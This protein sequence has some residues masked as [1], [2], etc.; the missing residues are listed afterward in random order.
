MI[1][2]NQI[3]LTKDESEDKLKF[4]AASKLKIPVSDIKSL[5][6]VKKSIDARKKDSIFYTYSLDIAANN[7]DKILKKCKE[8]TRSNEVIYKVTSLNKE[9]GARPVIVGCGPAGL[10]CAYVLALSGFK[11]IVLERGGSVDERAKKVDAFWETGK[12]D[13]ET[14]VQFGEGGAGTFSDGK[15]N[16]MVKDTF[17]RIHFVLE[18]FASF[19]AD[20][21][22]VYLNKPHIGTDVLRSVIKNMR[23]K[24]IE[25]GG[26]FHFNTK[27]TELLYSNGQ[28][29]G[30]KCEDGSVYKTDNVVL[31]IGHSA[32]DTFLMLSDFLKMEPKAFAMGVRCEHLQDTIGKSQYG[33]DYKSYPPADYKLTY[34]TEKGRSVYS[35]CMCPGGYVVNASSEQGRLAVNGMSY[36]KRDGKNAN[37]AIVVNI[38][39]DDFN[40][41][42]FGGME[43]QRSLEEAAYNCGNGNVP[44]QRFEDFKENR[45][46]E[47]FGSITPCIKGGHTF[48]N[49]RN[50]LPDFIS[51]AIIEGINAFGKKISGYDDGDA[52]LE[53]V[54]SRTSS[55]V[56]ILRDPVSLMADINGVYPCG[57]GAGY[58][59]GITSA[60]VDG[61]KIAECIINKENG[62]N[63]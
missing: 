56:R 2:I 18:T 54:E 21:S 3:K 28:I 55:P 52:L 25:M 35:F 40:G 48:G 59:G 33:S 58:A 50:V 47:N 53:A 43:L 14:N 24:I 5:K 10:F 13:P 37:S 61:I 4:K 20:P 6:I 36:S 11:P 62:D 22:I 16:T 39:P 17:G 7:E 27:V 31:A 49:L 38:T 57:E 15:L 19:G 9:P 46:T 34:T 30:V 63:V 12:L 41:E 8:A 60:A 45:K 42:L 26:E 1:R 29:T 44:V 32:R 23:E 51:E